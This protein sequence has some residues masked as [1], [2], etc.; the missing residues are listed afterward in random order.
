MDADTVEAQLLH[1]LHLLAECL[2]ARRGQ[3]GL[4]PVVLGEHEAEKVGTSIQQEP[5]S[6]A[7]DT[8]QSDVTGHLVDDLALGA[9]SHGGI[10]EVRMGWRPQVLG[11]V[12][13]DGH[14]VQGEV[15]LHHLR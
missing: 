11:P 7:G 15:A 2:R 6:G 14:R 12:M 8:A 10:D 5:R 4:R 1:P 3:M 13:G 9:E